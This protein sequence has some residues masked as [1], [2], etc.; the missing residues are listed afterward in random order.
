MFIDIVKIL[1]GGFCVGLA[2]S[3]TVGPVA[4]LCIQR[5][6]SKGHLSGLLSGLGIACADTLMAILAFSV[7]ALLKSYIDQY[8]TI[9]QFC[10]GLFV[11]IVGV[12]IFFKNPV[13]QIRKNRTGRSA[14]WQDFASMFGFTLANFVV[15]IPYI[16][17]FFTMFNIDL[18][19]NVEAESAAAHVEQWVNNVLVLG[20]FLLG[21]MS[22]WI[23]LTSIIN[24][25]RKGFKP[26][27]M[28]AINRIAGIVIC[29]LGIIT[30]ISVI[31]S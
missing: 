18:S 2:S 25:F 26:R 24:I 7:Y 3:V 31:I 13:P 14:L 20:G 23:A 22:W 8:N 15:V 5:T 17:A 27:H 28:L 21:A 16:L 29:A 10:G 1:F 11:V 9:I 12:L 30:L 4:V 19:L 6:L